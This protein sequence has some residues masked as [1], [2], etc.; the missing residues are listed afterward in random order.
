MLRNS[1]MK[2]TIGGTNRKPR[3]PIVEIEVNAE[4]LLN[5]VD[6]PAMLKTN[7]TTQETPT[8]IKT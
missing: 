4:P 6:L 1:E 5:F 3:Y 2:P 8:P 7:G